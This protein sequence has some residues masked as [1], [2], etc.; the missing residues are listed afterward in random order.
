MSEHS[1]KTSK[2]HTVARGG[3]FVLL[4]AAL[5]A[6]AYLVA[7]F[8]LHVAPVPTIPGIGN[9][10]SSKSVT[11]A[12]TQSPSSPDVRTTSGLA[13]E[14]AFVDNVYEGLTK[15]NNSNDPEP[16]LASSWDVSSDALTYTFHLRD[17]LKF[18]NGDTLKS[19]D[20]VWSLQQTVTKKYVD[21]NLLS[22][23]SGVTATDDSTVVVKLAEPNPNLLWVLGGRAGL[24]Y[25]RS[26]T[27]DFDGDSN[28]A[29]PLGSG[30]FTI[31]T[32][33]ANK[34]VTLNRNTNYW[35][36]QSHLASVTLRSFADLGGREKVNQ[37]LSKGT[38]QG[39]VGLNAAQVAAAKK[40][41]H[42]HVAI[43]ETTTRAL[44]VYNSNDNSLLS[45]KRYREIMRMTLDK[46]KLISSAIGGLGTTIG[47]PVPSLDPGYSDLT[48]IYGTDLQKGL[49]ERAYFNNFLRQFNLAY[50]DDALTPVVNAIVAQYKATGMNIIVHHL[51]ASDW[52]KKVTSSM[53]YDMALTTTVASHDA[54]IWFSGKN[55][56]T[57]DSPDADDQYKQAAAATTQDAYE[58]G[59]KK[60]TKTLV[61]GAP[62]DWLYT[63]KV[64]AAWNT[65]MSGMTTNMTERHL[66]LARLAKTGDKS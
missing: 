10:L 37:A 53:Q 42:L 22:G 61:E 27:A 4:I 64:A 25:D 8:V 51:N 33:A 5:C 31:G 12:V 46:K 23:L 29:I 14:Q 35:G 3:I 21:S 17:N 34:S 6:V 1:A 18:S 52:K 58:A 36:S 50:T 40:N 49:T 57:F 24:V 2:R 48:G 32:F 26:A 13:P 44:V 55:W 65:S 16:S 7:A 30:P 15:R 9:N 66:P 41:S 11:L 39:A 19:S 20:V 60:A 63:E 54:G 56:W 62:A 28:A 59:L 45:D 38:L 43:G 47:G